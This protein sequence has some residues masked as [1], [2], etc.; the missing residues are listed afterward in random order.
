MRCSFLCLCFSC[1]TLL[2]SPQEASAGSCCGSG[3][4]LGQRL[5]RDE[6]AA[7]TLSLRFADRFGSYDLTSRLL[8]MPPGAFDG[9]GRAEFAGVIA[10]MPRLQLGVVVPFVV[11]V[12]Q[13]PL[14][15]AIGGGF[16][17]ITASSRFDVI[18]LTTSNAWPAIAITAALTFP[19]GRSAS[20]ATDALAADATGL[21][22][23]EFR[24]GI[25]IEKSFSGRAS[26]VFASSLGLRGP[27]TDSQ[28]QPVQLAPRLRM[29]AAAGPVFDMGLSFSAGLIHEYEEA[30]SIGGIAAPDANRRRTAALLFVG[31]DISKHLTLLGS[32]DV[33]LPMRFVGKN[34]P[35]AM[36]VSI[37]LRRSFSVEN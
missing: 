5:A 2:F 26:A 12:R 32:F 34:E 10:P 18:P 23:V 29:I 13:F 33:D 15:S 17:D 1:A 31:Y 21:G 30:P 24:P 36:S 11:N 35:A 28:G 8:N 6:H 20:D 7:L 16:G 25:F 3:H 37:G 27:G 22:V 4:G 19:T 9:E 14:D